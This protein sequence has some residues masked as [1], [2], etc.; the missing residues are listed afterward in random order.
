MIYTELCVSLQFA[1][2][3]SSSSCNMASDD[4]VESR[5]LPHSPL[6]TTTS[7]AP[8]MFEFEFLFSGSDICSI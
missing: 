1:F 8:K 4:Y 6:K 7:F 3:K 2:W 5:I